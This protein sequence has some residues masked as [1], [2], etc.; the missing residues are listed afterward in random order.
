MGGIVEFLQNLFGPLVSVLGTV[1]TFFH[2]SVGVD[3]WISIALLTIVV[4][5]LLFPLTIKQVKSMRAMQDLKP[6]M[7]QVRAK[8]QNNRQK[9]QEELMKL[10]QER[11]VNPLGGCLPLLVQ[12]P[13][14][15]GLFYT[16]RQF[17]GTTG[18]VGVPDT[19]GTV[20]SFSHGGT[21][22]FADLTAP[23]PLYLLPIL[24]AVTMLVSMEI[25]NKSMEPQQRWIMRILPVVFTV[26]TLNFPAGLL[27]YLVTTNLVTFVQNYAI[28][29]YGPGRKA[30][31]PERD[32]W[33]GAAEQRGKGE[34]PSAD[35]QNA[36]AQAKKLAKRKRRK[37]KK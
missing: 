37:K 19:Q 7:D 15:L 16:L 35:S 6:E 33:K 1:L 25:T 9:Q 34:Q 14:F 2:D 10:Y 29:N 18:I 28:Y 31:E 22:W 30:K 36:Q 12:M 20:P 23:D 3:W 5:T 24:S 8:Y 26:F 13:I 17:G 27:I 32:V 11:G 4:R 21:L